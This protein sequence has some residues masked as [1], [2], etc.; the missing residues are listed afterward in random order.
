MLLQEAVVKS[1]C[2]DGDGVLDVF[3]LKAELPA[4]KLHTDDVAF[5]AALND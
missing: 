3:C 1:G 2:G 5:G 4:Q